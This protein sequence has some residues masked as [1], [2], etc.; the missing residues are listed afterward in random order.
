MDRIKF[1][2][3]G[4]LIWIEVG[5]G[6]TFIV[7]TVIGNLISSHQMPQYCVYTLPPSAFSTIEN[8][9]R[10]GNLPYNI[11]DGTKNGNKNILPNV[12]NLI[13]HDHLRLLSEKLV[14][15]A[16]STFLIIDEFHLLLDDT[17]RTSIGL[18]LA[19]LSSNFIGMTGTLIKDKDEK[20]VIQW[21]SQVVEFEVT[22]KNYMIGVASLISRK[23]NL[24]IEENRIF[25]DVPMINEEYYKCVTSDF[26]G[27]A[28]RTQFKEAVIICYD[29]LYNA[30]LERISHYLS[31]DDYPIFVVVKDNVTQLRLNND[32]K[33]INTFMITNKTSINLTPDMTTDLK[34]IITTSRHSTGYTLTACKTMITGVYFSNEATRSQLVGR[35]LRMGQRSNVV[36][37]EILHTGLLSYTLEH[38]EDCRS[39]TKTLS[40]LAKS[41]D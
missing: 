24:G 32:L 31:M 6:K 15:I 20:K 21:L 3:R 38:Y 16:N 2:K 22:P 12:I 9:L 23:L 10:L 36:N 34:V 33:N 17:K 39:I 41:V 37:I 1:N 28:M 14:E 5:Q 26:G 13:K 18:E 25:I 4:N 7:T 11:I 40:D 19:K 30:I 35:I 27:T 29:T 8:E